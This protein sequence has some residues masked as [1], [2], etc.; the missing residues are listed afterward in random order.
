MPV[1]LFTPFF[2]HLKKLSICPEHRVALSPPSPSQGHRPPPLLSLV[3]QR[4][5][6]EARSRASK[7]E[8]RP[9][10]GAGNQTDA[11]AQ[12]P[13]PCP[14]WR[15]ETLPAS[16]ALSRSAQRRSVAV[17]RQQS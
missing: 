3:S 10:A 6:A 9:V 13:G 11:P 5:R 16:S 4:T 8:A 17:R 14:D 7:A 12:I 2:Q 15:L 1:K